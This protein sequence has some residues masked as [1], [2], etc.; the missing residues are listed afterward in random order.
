MPMT[1]P[2]ACRMTHPEAWR[3]T[4]D[5][6]LVC[7]LPCYCLGIDRSRTMIRPV[8]TELVRDPVARISISGVHGR[9]ELDDRLERLRGPRTLPGVALGA[10]VL[11]AAFAAT[12][13]YLLKRD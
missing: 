12:V 4:H 3:M 9:D 7:C 1:H 8:R 11:G 13:A 2:Q 6:V 10:L 5:S